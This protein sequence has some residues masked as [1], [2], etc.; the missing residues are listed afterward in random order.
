MTNRT[1]PLVLPK[2]TEV[3][4]AVVAVVNE[5][6]MRLEGVVLAMLQDEDA[7]GSKQVVLEDKIGQGGELLK[8]IGRIGKDKRELLVAGLEE[9]E[10]VAADEQVVVSTNLL[11]ALSDEAGVVTVCL[12]AD[13]LCASPGEHLQRDAAGAG[14]EVEGGDAVEVEV[15]AEHVED[16]FLGKVCGWSCLKGT[17]HVEVT[18]FIDASDDSHYFLFEQV[19]CCVSGLRRSLLELEVLPNLSVTMPKVYPS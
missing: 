6:R 12:H 9:A 2:Q 17:W 16:V 18:A 14:K 5:M 1:P 10:G 13:D 11:H 8:R 3:D 15:A 4:A 19:E 7:V